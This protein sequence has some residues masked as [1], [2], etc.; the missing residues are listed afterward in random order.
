MANLKITPVQ[1][2]ALKK[3]IEEKREFLLNNK[4]YTLEYIKFMFHP[5]TPNLVIIK[6]RISGIS[7]GQ[8]FDD[9][10]YDFIDDKGEAVEYKMN[11]P[12]IPA[13]F[14][15]TSE[16]KEFNI[17]DGKPVFVN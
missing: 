16:M 14:Q 2:N 9:I 8:P 6:M 12:S 10:T 3:Y 11:F 13:W 4:Y 5:L 17:I 7:A 15:Y 1:L